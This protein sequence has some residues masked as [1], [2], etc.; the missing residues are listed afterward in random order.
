MNM[1]ST[2]LARD[3]QATAAKSATDLENIPVLKGNS[4]K[5]PSGFIGASR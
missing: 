1:T 3:N 5:H 4:I 2:P